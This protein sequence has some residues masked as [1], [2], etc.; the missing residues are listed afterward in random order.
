MVSM[1]KT[2]GGIWDRRKFLQIGGGLT[3]GLFLPNL[4]RASADFGQISS[5]EA[6]RAGLSSERILSFFNTHTAETCRVVYWRRGDY[7]PEGLSA[8]NQVLRDHRT[9]EVKPI[10]PRLLDLLNSLSLRLKAMQPFHV[11]S[12]YRSPQTNALLRRQGHRIARKSLHMVGQAVDIR[13][14][15]CP[16]A[17]LRRVALNL[18]GGGV[19]FYPRSDF[20]HLDVGPVRSW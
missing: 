2:E 3:L 10:D 1:T 9:G 15:Q 14:P 13:L 20:V 16:L 17:T 5:T 18:R 8:I 4:A 6:L 19:G 12:G 11:V 7:W